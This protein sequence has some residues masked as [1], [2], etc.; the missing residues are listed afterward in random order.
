M[1]PLSAA[2]LAVAEGASRPAVPN[3]AAL[4]RFYPTSLSSTPSGVIED[5]E[6][7]LAKVQGLMAGAPAL[8]QQSLLASQSKQEFTANVAL[9]DQIQSGMIK[10]ANLDLVG[11]AKGSRV[12]TKALGDGTNTVYRPL[13]PCRIMDSRNASLAS[14]VQGPLTGNTLYTLPGFITDGTN[15]GQY[16]GSGSSDCGLDSTYGSSIYGVA[17]VITVLNP[18]FDAFLGVSEGNLATTLSTVAVNFTHGQGLSTLYIVP[19]LSANSIHFAMPA[20]LSANVIFDVVGFFHRSDATALDCTSVYNASNTV[21]PVG[22]FTS[23][24]NASIVACPSGY[25]TTSY[26]FKYVSG[27]GSISHWFNDPEGDGLGLA[28]APYNSVSGFTNM[29]ITVGRRC[30]RVPGR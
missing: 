29:T 26:V 10:Q 8:L 27:I 13:A 6:V 11:Q 7:W 1:A 19:Q 28:H 3:A 5:Q 22:S 18:T 15:W 23:L 21:V 25:E 24:A 30:C 9:L 4:L 17:L 16:G 14:G 2:P 20:G 12:P